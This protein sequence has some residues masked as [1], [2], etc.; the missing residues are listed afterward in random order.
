MSFDQSISSAMARTM[1]HLSDFAF[2]SMVTCHPHHYFSSKKRCLDHL[3]SSIKPDTGCSLNCPL[4]MATLF[5]D[6]A[7]KKVEN[8][9]VQHENKGYFGSSSHQKGQHNPYKRSVKSFHDGS[10]PH[11]RMEN[12]WRKWPWKEG[13]K[14]GK[15]GENIRLLIPTGQ[16]S[17]IL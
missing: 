4:H 1:Q 17:V 5:L 3:R 15:A 2:V 13:E 14:Q 10:S 12:C 7:L 8:D 6:S 11:S 9:I 16:G